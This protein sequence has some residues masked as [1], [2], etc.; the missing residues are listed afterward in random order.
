MTAR[1]VASLAALL[2]A[3]P[4]TAYQQTTTADGRFGLRWTGTSV[5]WV[6]NTSRSFSSPSCQ[7]GGAIDPAQDA[8]RAAFSAWETATRSGEAAPCSRLALP[9]GGPSPSIRV[10]GIG[11]SSTASEHLVVFRAGW[12]SANPAAVADTCYAAGDCGNEYNCFDDQGGL[13][14]NVLA[15][16]TVIYAP[17]SGAI[18]DADM[19]IVD[20]DGALGSLQS[21]PPDG[22]YWTCLDPGSQSSHCTF[23][24]QEGCAFMDLQNTATHEAGHFIG[25]AHPCETDPGTAQQNGVPVCTGS[26]MASTTMYPSAAP[27][28]TG[29]RTLDQDDVNGVCTVYSTSQAPS[30]DGG[31]DSGGGC[32]SGG[33]T[34][35]GLIALGLALVFLRPRRRRA[36]G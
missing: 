18:A 1:I 13:G 36:R 35:A 17:S 4:A 28:E 15:L 2:A 30:P 26:A 24:G 27:G 19:E 32:G 25:L 5:P 11:S 14:R 9:F 6:L 3:A 16:T 29:K 21:P 10:A 23:Y 33:A 20:W 31:R 7:A 8:V 12:C 34:P 22:W